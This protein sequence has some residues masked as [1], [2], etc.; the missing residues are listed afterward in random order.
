M[1]RDEWNQCALMLGGF[2][3]MFEGFPLEPAMADRWHSILDDFPAT[4]VREAI[5]IW[6]SNR[7]TPPT[8]AELREILAYWAAYYEG[9]SA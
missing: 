2:F 1:T 4:W 7:S 5:R 9:E 6:A 3:F 8:A